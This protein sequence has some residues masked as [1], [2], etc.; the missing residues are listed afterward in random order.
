MKIVY[1][2]YYLLNK[3]VL[4]L[5]LCKTGGWSVYFASLNVFFWGAGICFYRWHLQSGL[6]HLNEKGKPIMLW[7]L[8]SER[9]FESVSQ[10]HPR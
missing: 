8:T 10:K 7:M 6:N 9:L 5:V 3:V 4:Y 2:F 1:K